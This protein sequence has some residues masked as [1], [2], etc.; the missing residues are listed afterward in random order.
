MGGDLVA[1][2]TERSGG[3]V[4]DFDCPEDGYVIRS[5]R[6]FYILRASSPLI[7]VTLLRL[8]NVDEQVCL[9]LDSSGSRIDHS[10]EAYCLELRA[11]GIRPLSGEN[12]P[13]NPVTDWIDSQLFELSE[14]A[15]SFRPVK[16]FGVPVTREQMI[17]FMERDH[18]LKAVTLTGFRLFELHQQGVL[19]QVASLN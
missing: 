14:A 10:S 11:R 13:G 16:L 4:N 9:L 8:A 17:D 19:R 1:R 5:G 3:V 12:K 15:R 18:F 6:E 7:V 2:E